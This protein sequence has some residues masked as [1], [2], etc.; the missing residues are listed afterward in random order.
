MLKVQITAETLGYFFLFSERII[1]IK[2]VPEK[3]KA[4]VLLKV[5]G[6]RTL[7]V[8]LN[9]D[10]INNHKKVVLREFQSTPKMVFE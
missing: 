8:Y 3:M 7:I 6:E 9:A 4:E 1:C 10:R 2:N 5:L